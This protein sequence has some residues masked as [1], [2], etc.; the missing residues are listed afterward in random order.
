MKKNTK[1]RNKTLAEKVRG[2]KVFHVGTREGVLM[3]SVPYTQ[4][5]FKNSLLVVSVMVNLFFFIGWLMTQ[6]STDYAHAI[7]TMIA[8]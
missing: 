4:Q 3:A 5:D 6:V 7:A 1:T 2:N 8:K